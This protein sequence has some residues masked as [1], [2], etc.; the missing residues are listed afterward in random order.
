MLAILVAA[1]LVLP[2]GGS[3][4]GS[5]SGSEAALFMLEESEPE[6]DTSEP[7][8]APTIGEHLFSLELNDLEPDVEPDSTTITTT[9]PP[10]ES[11]DDMLIYGALLGVGIFVL[12]MLVVYCLNR[13]PNP[14][15]Q[16]F[17]PL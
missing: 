16:S 5:E 8:A 3:G 1:A 10:G 6:S 14:D 11:D 13:K 17:T 4:S 2:V 12:I 9:T 7:T 15:P